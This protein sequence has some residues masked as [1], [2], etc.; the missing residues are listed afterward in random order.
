MSDS[1]YEPAERPPAAGGVRYRFANAEYDEVAGVLAVQGVRVAVELRPLRL[2]AELLGRV[3]E[4]VTK[5]ELFEALWGGRVT[6]DHVLANA[7][8]KLRAALGPEAG[9]RIVNVPRVG[10]RLNGP[11]KRL[12][13]PAVQHEL[14]AGQAVP[15][16]SGYVLERRLDSATGSQVWLARSAT[17]GQAHVFKFADDSAGLTALKREHTIY[18]VLQA[19][20][21]PR[22][23]FARVVDTHFHSA[24]YFIQ[25]EYGGANLA[26]WAD[27]GG[28]LAAM[29]LDER[30]SLFLQIARAVAAAHSVGVL[31]KDIKPANVLIDGEPTKWQIRLTDFGTGRLLEPA[32][33][34]ALE[35]T[36][37][38]MLD[39]QE[40]AVDP[41]G[42][43]MMYLAPE[44]MCGNASTVQSD[45]YALGVMLYQIVVGDLR[46]PLGTGWQ[47]EVGDELLVNDITSATQ[48]D[49]TR[50][51]LDVGQLLERVTQLEQRHARDKHLADMSAQSK[52]TMADLQRRR[53][54]RP[55]VVALV[56]TLSLMVVGAVAQSLLIQKARDNEALERARAERVS[57]FLYRDV[58]HAPDLLTDNRTKPVQMIDVLRRAATLAP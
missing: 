14:V 33:L 20:L 25:C 57:D 34:A 23:D 15:G 39:G 46:R 9:A 7:V 47:R 11:V 18:R 10:Y 26:A 22:D 31:H 16:R 44:V 58:L 42:A 32:R 55:W 12:A 30:L 13:S 36:T 35:L 19:E 8:S 41:G 49:V 27:E 6:V 5:D 51:L 45:V 2:L 43:T 1:H 53:A 37:S 38:G 56:L 28:Q 17:L 52:A 29:S 50:R 54:R 21:G 24:P 3:N 48:V 40:L 4:V